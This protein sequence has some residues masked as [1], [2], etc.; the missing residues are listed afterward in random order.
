MKLKYVKSANNQTVKLASQ[1]KQK[2]YRKQRNSFLLEGPV[3]VKEAL[4][5]GADVQRIF[6]LEQLFAEEEKRGFFDLFHGEICLV[7]HDVMAKLSE[8]ENSQGVVAEVVFKS[9]KLENFYGFSKV[10]FL[11]GVQD[12]GNV[13]TII[14]TA[15]GMGIDGIL[16][17]VGTAELLNPKVVRATMASLMKMP[18]LENVGYEDL[19]VL[20]DKG[21]TFVGADVHDGAKP[22]ESWQ[23]IKRSLLC[24]GNEAQG[25]S[26]ELKKLLDGRYFIPMDDGVES[27]NVGVAAGIMLYH[28]KKSKTS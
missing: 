18:I 23:P 27:L 25:L 4:E 16:L 10:I 22:L 28:W 1:L 15:N 6:I 3:V 7:T 17:G 11:D 24:L 13:G 21:F 2:K 5:A 26:Q 12:P 14:R 20:K 8:T 19:K 9:W